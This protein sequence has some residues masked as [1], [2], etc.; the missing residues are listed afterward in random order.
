MNDKKK[1]LV[2]IAWPYAN[3]DLHVGHIAG[4]YLPADIYARY[5]R[6]AG[7]DVLV[8]SGSD[9]H[10][11]PITVRADQE[12]VSPR[13]IYERYHKRFLETQRDIGISYNLFT[14]T[15]TP[16]HHRVSQDIFLGL[17]RNGYLYV[18]KQQ[19][20]YSEVSQQ[21][22]PDRYV[23]GTCPYCDYP[24]ARG[25][26]CDNCGRLL[27]ALELKNPR[28]KIDG[29]T[30]VIRETEHF[31]LDLEKLEPRVLDYLQTGKEEWRPNV[32]KFSLNYV[33]GGL[34]GRPITRDIE[35]GIPV[36]LDG[37][38]GKRLYVWFEAVIGYLSA[39]IEWSRLIGDSDAWKAWWYDPQ[40]LTIYFIGK[41]NIPFHAIIWP[42]E[43]MGVERLYED[44]PAKRLNLPY[45]VPANEFMNLSG[46]QFS[47]SRGR[48]IAVPDLLQ[49]YD[50]D[51][52][53]YYVTVV[54][55][56]TSDSDFYWDDFVQRNNGEL[57]GV[58][59]NLA[60]RVLSFTYKHFGAVPEPGELADV[61]RELLA[62]TEA[63]FDTVG[64]HLAGRRFRAA[65]SEA[66][67]LAREANRYLEV[68]SPW[69]QIKTDRAASATSLYMALQ[70]INALKV[71]LAPFL[72]FSAEK[73]HKTLGYADQ[74]FGI[75]YI[76][77][78][79]AEGQHY[80]VLRYDESLAR[81]RW[82][83]ETLPAGRVLSQPSPLFKKLDD[84]VIDEELARL[85]K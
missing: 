85:G 43:L 84:S 8:V 41:D 44:D 58:W 80:S 61:D 24:E 14:H 35:W 28:S 37:Y 65:L 27:D 48:M 64:A 7:N 9:S 34:K 69:A 82:A 6:L 51:A 13:E 68:K 73:L 54:M 70:A 47:K 66:M 79:E 62:K 17:L 23:E 39:S 45:D 75:Q 78:V 12:G 26:Q 21:F 25:D 5:H 59:G 71:L 20:Y 33:K 77:E 60:H 2:S 67:N 72:P 19:Q 40:A 83:F 50:A 36:P 46:A 3:G 10:G 15:D 55:P 56:E 18:E 16:N 29:A 38:A 74:L 49:R 31:F 63:A 1:V 22:L 57:V 30:P 76:E 53:R 32:L 81:G 42:A 4:A 52:I 11:T